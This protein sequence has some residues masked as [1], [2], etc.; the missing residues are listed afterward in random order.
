M[1]AGI[2]EKVRAGARLSFEDG[3]R[4]F[5]EADLFA[6]GRLAEE[7]RRRKNGNRAYYVRN[8][9]INYSN[10]CAF[11]CAFCGFRRAKGEEGAWEMP[12]DEVFRRAAAFGGERLDEIHIVGGAHPDL[13]YGYYLEMLR[14]LKERFPRVHIKAFTATEIDWFCR[15][16]GRGV[17]EVLRDLREAGLGSLPGGGAEILSERVW[18]IACGGKA[19]PARWLDIHR[20]WHRMGGRSTCTM[21][22][23]HIETDDERVAHMLRLRDLQD[24]TGGFTAFVPLAFRPGNNRLSHLPAPTARVDIAVHAVA[25]L[26]LD[27]FDH[28]KAYWVITGLKMAQILLAFGADDLDGTVV[29]ERVLHMSGADSPPGVSEED[30]CAL[31]RGAGRDPVRRDSLY[32]PVPAGR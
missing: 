30:L 28:V 25:R 7:V 29:E 8:A 6:L 10:V 1:P 2:E 16:S 20:T 23:G 9:H 19:R 31:I 15:I 26:M 17:E 22:Y 3:V 5:R 27:N 12:L 21:L 18:D 11:D 24:E 14:G 32:R 4:L 13:P